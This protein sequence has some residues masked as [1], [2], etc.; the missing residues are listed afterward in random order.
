[1]L[2]KISVAGICPVAVVKDRDKVGASP[3]LRQHIVGC[4]QLEDHGLV[5]QGLEAI[6]HCLRVAAGAIL[7]CG[8]VQLNVFIHAH[9]G[10]HFFTYRIVATYVMCTWSMGACQSMM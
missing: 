5:A 1:M 7:V 2:S 9:R 3:H 10:H 4:T 8:R 6:N